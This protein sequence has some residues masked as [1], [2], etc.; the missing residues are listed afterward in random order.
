MKIISLAIN[1]S[2]P[3]LELLEELVIV[4]LI[5]QRHTSSMRKFSLSIDSRPCNSFS[6]VEQLDMLTK[7]STN[8]P[9]C[10]RWWLVNCKNVDGSILLPLTF[11]LNPA[12]SKILDCEKMLA[13]MLEYL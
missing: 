6:E 7:S 2:N 4:V 9:T 12:L 13:E 1:V 5:V 3:S 10:S 8:L 11:H